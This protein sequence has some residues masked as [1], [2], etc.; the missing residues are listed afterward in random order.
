MRIWTVIF[1]IAS[2]SAKA[3]EYSTCSTWEE[4]VNGNAFHYQNIIRIS[5]PGTKENPAYTGF[6]FYDEQQFDPTDRYMLGMKIHFQER[7]VEPTDRGEIGYFD[8]QDRNKWTKIGETTAWNWQQV[9]RLQWRPNSHEIV[10]NDRSDDDTHFVCR[11]YHFKTGMRR[12]LPRAIYDISDD[13]KYALTH[14]FARMKHAGTSYV[15]IPDPY[16]DQLAPAESGIEKMNMDT[17]ETEFLIS[18]ETNE[19]NRISQRIRFNLPTLFFPRRMEPLWHSFYRLPA[20]PGSPSPC[21]RVVAL[22]RWPRC[23]LFL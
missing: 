7:E 22:G 21:F 23:P 14:D 8:L 4:L 12:T 20:K 15:G 19:R 18:L 3:Q 16:G 5:D 9:C 6:W 17:G 10:W 1:L 11:T 2:I 13:G